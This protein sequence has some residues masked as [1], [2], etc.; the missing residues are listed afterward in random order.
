MNVKDLK[1]IIDKL[2]LK[3]DKQKE[4]RGKVCSSLVEL[5]ALKF[6]ADQWDSLSQDSKESIRGVS[7]DELSMIEGSPDLFPQGIVFINQKINFKDIVLKSNSL[8]DDISGII[9]LLG[10]YSQDVFNRLNTKQD[11][12]YLNHKNVLSVI[13]NELIKEDLSGWSRDKIYDLLRDLI[14]LSYTYISADAEDNITPR[15][16]ANFKAR[17]IDV[18]RLSKKDPVLI[19]DQT[20]YS[21]TLLVATRDYLESLGFDVSV[22]S[23]GKSNDLA[24]LLLLIKYGQ[25]K[26]TVEETL[27]V[28]K[29]SGKLGAYDL[30]PESVPNRFDIILLDPPQ[31][32]IQS[33]LW[34]KLRRLLKTNGQ[35]IC[36]ANG[37]PLNSNDSFPK[38]DKLNKT[39]KGPLVQLVEQGFIKKVCQLGKDVSYATNIDQYVIVIDN[40][41]ANPERLIQVQNLS[42]YRTPIKH[43]FDNK[44]QEFTDS[45]IEEIISLDLLPPIPEV[46]SFILP[47][48]TL[49]QDWKIVK[50]GEK[51]SII[52]TTPYSP[53][54]LESQFLIKTHLEK[55]SI[56]IGK[57]EP[58]KAQ[59]VCSINFNKIFY[60]NNEIRPISD[61]ESEL[62][63]INELLYNLDNALREE[64]K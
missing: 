22:F 18:S 50:E 16:I 58:V 44:R 4:E 14:E 7:K 6:L 5:I 24:R 60:K 10:P 54:E 52:E 26:V 61:L 13:C 40:Q 45:K 64:R 20:D 56:P 55:W 30:D 48:T 51:K 28:N 46:T 31:D 2:A 8:G 63:N 34:Y 41:N 17:L 59:V 53:V 37:S 49:C 33:A 19:A 62:D 47:I 27:E 3:G 57:K 12:K 43:T 25:N 38:K 15:D 29:D 32:E 36:L 9:S 35:M 42:S 23:Y 21:G 11:I 39:N 1:K